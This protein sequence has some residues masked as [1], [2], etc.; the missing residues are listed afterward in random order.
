MGAALRAWVDLSPAFGTV[1]QVVVL[2]HLIVLDGAAFQ[3][4]L[5][6]F[7]VQW[8][9]VGNCSSSQR[10]LQGTILSAFLFS[11][12]MGQLERIRKEAWGCSG[13][14]L[15]ITPKCRALSHPTLTIWWVSASRR[16]YFSSGHR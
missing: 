9:V 10:G 3:W 15:L 1:D 16:A 4:L 13:S 11:T 8:V 6:F 7:R 14:N 12:Y 2:T 5:Y